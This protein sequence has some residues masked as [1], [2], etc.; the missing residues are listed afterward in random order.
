[1]LFPC[2]KSFFLGLPISLGINP[3]ILHPPARPWWPGLRF[4]S[5]S[6]LLCPP[7]SQASRQTTL[8]LFEGGDRSPVLPWG[9]CTSGSLG[10]DSSSSLPECASSFVSFK[11][12][13]K[14]CLSAARSLSWPPHLKYY[15]VLLCIPLIHFMLPSV[16]YTTWHYV[17]LCVSLF[18]VLTVH[19]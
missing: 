12:S 3:R 15:S 19:H 9:L 1:M 13:F 18:T 14:S 16:T 2:S 6:L 5:N 4:L 8:L 11:V 10:L 17:I 7:S